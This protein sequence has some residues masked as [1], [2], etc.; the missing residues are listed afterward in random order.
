MSGTYTVTVTRG[1]SGTSSVVVQSVPNPV[2]GIT[3][4]MEYLFRSNRPAGGDGR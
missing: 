3:G 1:C 4:D 2:K